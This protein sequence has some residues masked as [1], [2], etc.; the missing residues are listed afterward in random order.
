[1]SIQNIRKVASCLTGLVLVSQADA[2]ELTVPQDGW[3]SWQVEAV[4]GAPALC[5]WSNWDKREASSASC[6]LDDDRGNYG[7]RDN[8]TTDAV[9]VYARM[10][11]GKVERLRAFSATCPVEAATPIRD[12]GNV[13]TD[14]STR[15]L[16][17]L[18]KPEANSSQD[19]GHHVLAALAV[20]RGDLAQNELTAMA[21]GNS[22]AETRKNAVFWLAHL[23]GTAGAEVATAVMFKD[24]DPE[25]RQHAAFAITQ[26]KSPSVTSDLIRLGNTDKDGDVRAQAWFWLAHTGAPGSEDAIGAALRKD[27]DEHVREHAIFALSQL[28]DERATR[29]LIAAAEDRSLSSEQRKRAVFWL[30]QSESPGAQTYLE[31]VLTRAIA[32]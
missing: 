27:N 30:A 6:K 24:E 19:F 12:L 25:L 15:W 29:A 20:H 4:E 2:A 3:A 8:A 18:T 10:A 23:R 11:G 32:H 22:A 21:R 16:I 31:K 14:D 5:C 9:R 26:S 28:P 13:V 7:T 17:K 1:M